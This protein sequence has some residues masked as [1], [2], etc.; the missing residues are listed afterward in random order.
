MCACV[1]ALCVQ[2]AL[3]GTPHLRACDYALDP[4]A[5][6]DDGEYVAMWEHWQARAGDVAPWQSA[7][8]AGCPGEWPVVISQ[9]GMRRGGDR[10]NHKA[11]VR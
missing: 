6:L 10:G 5:I 8:G 7:S 1:R 9:R 4:V 11:A 2:V 3:S